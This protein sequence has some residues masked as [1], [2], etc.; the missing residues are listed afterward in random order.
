MKICHSKVYCLNGAALSDYLTWLIDIDLCFG[1]RIIFWDQKLSS[2]TSPPPLFKALSGMAEKKI[3]LNPQSDLVWWCGP[4]VSWERGKEVRT[5]QLLFLYFVESAC[6][7]LLAAFPWLFSLAFSEQD[8]GQVKSRGIFQK[9]S[10]RSYHHTCFPP[11]ISCLTWAC[12]PLN[13]S[14]H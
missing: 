14:Q 13:V 9:E 8:Q 3:I 1:V 7:F 2:N 12:I 11:L 6:L 5:T 10:F 4:T